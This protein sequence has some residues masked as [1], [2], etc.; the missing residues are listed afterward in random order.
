MSLVAASLAVPSGGLT[1]CAGGICQLGQALPVG[2]VAT[3]TVVAHINAGTVAG[4]VLTN[5]AA[6]LPETNA[7]DPNLDNNQGQS[8]SLVRTLASLQVD[9]FDLV[10][11]V[12]PDGTIVY[13]IILTNTGPS[14][15]Q[16]VVITDTLPPGVTFLSGNGCQPVTASLLS[17]T[18]GQLGAGQQTKL[19]L[20]VKVSAQTQN[21]VLLRNRVDVGTS[22]PLTASQ[23]SDEETTLIHVSTGM[24]ADLMLVKRA[25]SPTVM[26]ELVSFTIAITNNGPAPVS[27]ATFVDL[28]PPGLTLV[29]IQS[30]QGTC[31]QVTCF[32]GPLSFLTDA[33]GAPLVRGTATVTIVA[34]VD[35]NLIASVVLTNTASVQSD[36]P[37]PTPENNLDTAAW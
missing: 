36:R 7:I 30:S 12:E 31:S 15:A 20:V 11:P 5:T 4:S 24:L 34:C 17:C 33:Q 3:M 19:Q 14:D 13:V 22:T 26:A 35:A 25:N 1:A 23:L 27:S 10:D 9:K 8:A 18:V 16:N 29:S 32:L 21:G 37:D 28:L 2:E 6:V